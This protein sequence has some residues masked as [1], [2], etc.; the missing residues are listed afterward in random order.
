MRSNFSLFNSNSGHRIMYLLAGML[1]GISMLSSCVTTKTGAYF[2]TLTKDTVLQGFVTNDF[3][4]KIQKKDVLGIAVTSMNKE[5]DDRFN[6]LGTVLNTQQITQTGYLVSEKGSVLLHYLGEVPVEGL[7]RKEL[8]EK[9]EQ[10]LLPFMKE[11]IVSVQYLN[12]KVTILGEV[13][14]P[15][16]MNM[17]EEQMSLIDLIVSSGDVKENAKRSMVMVIREEK[18]TK[19]VKYLNLEDN[20]IFTSPWYYVQ[21]NDIVYV[22]PDNEKYIKAERRQKL[23]STI[24]LV[25][26]LA[27]LVVILLNVILR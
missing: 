21:P 7:T 4:S 15:Q 26:S 8:K 25:A 27:S 2:K 14:K 1:V 22:L 13:G 24:S 20:S 16:V 9:L 10:L 19:K 18:N 6:T 3:E 12:H 17:P 11:P 5:I 23:Q